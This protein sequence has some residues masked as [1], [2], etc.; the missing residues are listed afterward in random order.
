MDPVVKR[1]RNT[2]DDPP[3]GSVCSVR[4]KNPRM[5]ESAILVTQFLFAVVL[6]MTCNTTQ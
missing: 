1:V 2:V 4:N 6:E 5:S 3:D